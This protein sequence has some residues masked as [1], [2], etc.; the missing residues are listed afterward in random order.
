MSLLQQ[1]VGSVVKEVNRIEDY[2]QI[3]FT[4]E[5]VINV[6]NN[7]EFNGDNLKS[8]E[9][10]ELLSIFECDS[11]IDLHFRNDKMI[12]V[13]LLEKDYNGPEAMELHRKGKPPIIWN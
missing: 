4:D 8:I 2:L 10:E 1:L 7:F 11:R 9:K 3:E 13:S 5:T 12:S 6:N